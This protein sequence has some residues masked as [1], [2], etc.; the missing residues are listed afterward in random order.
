MATMNTKRGQ[1]KKDT[2]T[3]INHEG[4]TVHQLNSLEILFSK[5]L[6]SFFGESTHYEKRTADSD[7]Q[8]LVD[9]ISSV[10]DEDIEYVL[11]IARIGREHNMIQYPLAVLTT[12]FNDDR[13]K[14]EKFLDEITGKNKLQTYSDYIVRRGRDIL[15]VI[16]IQTKFY[17]FDSVVRNNI[18]HRNRPLPSQLRKALRYKLE[19]FSEYQLSKSLGES[20]EVSLADCIKL[21][22]PNPTK[23]RVS[24]DFYKRVL[25]G[26]V[27][28]GGSDETKQIQVEI[29]NAKNSNST[30]TIE[31]IKKSIKTSSLM[32]VVKNLMSLK[33]QGLLEDA[34]VVQ[35]IV[36]KLTN[37]QEVLKSRMLPFRFYS[38]YQELIHVCFSDKERM[39]IDALGEALDLSIENLPD[40]TGHSAILID[41]SGSMDYPI[42]SK[43]TVSA[44]NIALLLGAIMLKK[45]TADVYVFASEISRINPISR[46][47]P[48]IEIMQI[49]EHKNVGKATYLDTAL[50]YILNSDIKY[51]NLII[52]SDGDCYF[53]TKNPKSFTLQSWGG[54][55]TSTD[56]L[57]NILFKQ[58]VIKKLYL[59]NLLGNDFAIVNTDDYRKNLITGFSEKIVDIINIYSSI[60]TKA[61]DIRNII[62]SMIGDLPKRK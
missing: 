1:M 29:S 6:G 21:L 18:P 55:F 7:F 41:R 4:S 5:V 2:H 34:E 11:K 50:K 27:M 39:I 15:D 12:C 35:T 25:E 23:A 24:S 3:T 36:A 48:V 32:A 37:K 13:F 38:A 59:N 49:I 45:S 17:G 47:T 14:G 9:L 53:S 42:S 60:G 52:L 28:F 19:N 51:D 31:D 44:T 46:K 58:K 43:S 61:S 30:S 62:D 33:R 20:R 26:D 10:P 8:N 22:R 57:A 56:S 54:S 16:A 40:I